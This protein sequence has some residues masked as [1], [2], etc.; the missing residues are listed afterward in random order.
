LPGGDAVVPVR[1]RRLSPAPTVRP[2]SSFWTVAASARAG[3]SGRRIAVSGW[4]H[5]PEKERG[6]QGARPIESNDPVLRSGVWRRPPG[7]RSERARPASR[8]RAPGSVRCSH[9]GGPT[10]LIRSHWPIRSRAHL[11]SLH[12]SAVVKERDRS[13]LLL[14]PSAGHRQ[15]DGLSGSGRRCRKS[16]GSQMPAHASA[17]G[18]QARRMDAGV[19]RVAALFGLR[20]RGRWGVRHCGLSYP[21]RLRRADPISQA[22]KKA[23][24]DM[25]S[26]TPG[27]RIAGL[28][29]GRKPFWRAIF[30]ICLRCGATSPFAQ[31]VQTVTRRQSGTAVRGDRRVHR[32]FPGFP[33]GRFRSRRYGDVRAGSSSTNTPPGDAMRSAAG[34]IV[35]TTSMTTGRT[36]TDKT[37]GARAR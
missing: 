24:D 18:L 26:R 37:T 35:I 3:Q 14:G 29:S 17:I 10:R 20:R 13:R 22:R 36:T 16:L 34:T 31:Q 15:G 25:S 28:L 27:R 6:P 1:E 32:R 5:L 2:S 7:I 23:P 12:E 8:R 21:I 30:P 4:L 11:V 33:Q 9:R 19:G